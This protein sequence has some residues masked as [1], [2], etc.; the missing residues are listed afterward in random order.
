MISIAE[1]GINWFGDM[2]LAQKMIRRC[3]KAG[4]TIA[5]F[6]YYKPE[7]ILGKSSP[8][9]RDAKKS[10]LSPAKIKTLKSFCDEAGIEF[11][12]SVFHPENIEF[13]EKIG[14][15]RYKIASRSVNDDA[16]LKSINNTRKPVIMSTGMSTNK[17]ISHAL[18]ILKDC[19]VTLLYCVCKYPSAIEDINLDKMRG[20]KKFRTAVGFSSH[21]PKTQPT[22]EAVKRGAT[23]IENHVVDN[24]ESRGCDVS[25][26]M[27]LDVYSMMLQ[28]IREG[29]CN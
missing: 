12:L 19:P 4:A 6:Q 9:L 5:K 2:S 7:K 1:I 14:L 8:F 3:A 21:C 24:P 20:L 16:L 25:S 17:Q 22:L 15:Q 23:V 29:I 11:G 18:T 10:E 27:P 13:T 26:S 28:F